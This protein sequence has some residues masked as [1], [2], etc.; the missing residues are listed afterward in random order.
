MKRIVV[1]TGAGVSAESGIKTFRDA[2]GLWEGHDVMEVASPQG[3]ARNP[4]LVL[5]F[6]NQRRKQLL[7]VEPNPAHKALVRLEA[8]YDTQIITQN[9]DDLHERAGSSQV[10]HLHGELFKVRST[11]NEHTVMDWKKDLHLGDLCPEGYQLRPHIV[12]FG[13]MV[14]LL[15]TAAQ[16]V[17]CADII[18]I[19]G[20]SMQVYPAAGLIDYAPRHAAIYFID[21]KPSVSQQAYANLTVIPETAARGVPTVVENLLHEVY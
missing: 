8:S 11:R 1:L 9:I 6:Y 12:W 21:P 16:Q 4:E 3:F 2:G 10:L 13:E 19:I 7:T 14:P 5:E 20:T 17:Q 15:E 18:L